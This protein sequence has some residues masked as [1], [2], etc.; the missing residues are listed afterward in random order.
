MRESLWVT[1]LQSL[2]IIPCAFIP[3]ESLSTVYGKLKQNKKRP[4]CSRLVN[5]R[6]WGSYG[7]AHFWA[8]EHLDNLLITEIGC[9][10]CLNLC[11]F[12]SRIDCCSMFIIDTRP[13]PSWPCCSVGKFWDFLLKSE[14]GHDTDRCQKLR[15]L[16]QEIDCWVLLS[17]ELS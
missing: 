14:I 16:T 4:G 10:R 7:Q 12:D 2:R 6:S 9:D 1:V 3:P 15:F 8:W 11:F 5:R 13:C 17:L